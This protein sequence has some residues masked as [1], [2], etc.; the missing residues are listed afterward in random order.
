[1]KEWMKEKEA[2]FHKIAYGSFYAAVVIEVLIV[3]IDKSS[4]INPIEGRLFQ[5]T[6]LLCLVKVLL[7][8][9][10]RREYVAIFLFCVLGAVSYFVTERNEI[11]RL[12][13]LVVACKG[14]DMKK[15]L[16]LVFWMTLSGCLVIVLLSVTGLYG[17]VSL[18]QDYGRGC[19]ETRYTLGMGHP[20]ALQCMVFALTTL[21]L[22]LYGEKMRW[23]WYLLVVGVNGFLFLLTDSKTSFL[24]AALT[25]VLFVF[26]R[27]LKGKWVSALLFFGGLLA[28]L[29]SVVLSV[30]A[31]KDAYLIYR[32]R[33]EWYWTPKVE[34]YLKLDSLLTGR[35]NSLVGTENF[36]GTLQTWSLFSK[37]ENVYY[38]DMGWV[39]LFYWY[40]IVP[41]C[42]YIVVLLLLMIYCWRKRQNAALIMIMVFSLYTLIEAHGISEYLARNYVFFLLGGCFS[43]ML[44]CLKKK[45][46]KEE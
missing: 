6:F 2:L 43:P 35:I 42:I 16:K 27:C 33:W 41:A 13:M 10:T 3:L 25:I 22:Y 46:I 5:L 30:F 11:L 31:A 23:Y 37:P 8:R 45:R 15:C 21:G 17:A 26:I 14:V 9:Y 39:R 19:V 1:M 28:T 7:T 24:V 36:E 40:G 20:N 4:Y 38:F 32:F 18:T 44:D 34:I 29:G 12:V